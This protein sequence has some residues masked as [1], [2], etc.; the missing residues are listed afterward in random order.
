M[1]KNNDE[2][3]KLFQVKL[4]DRGNASS[5]FFLLTCAPQCDIIEVMP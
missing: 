4:R 3:E 1:E 2:T 5:F